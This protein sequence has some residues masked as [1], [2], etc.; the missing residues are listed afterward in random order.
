MRTFHR[1]A[2]IIIG[3]GALL[4]SLLPPASLSLQA[5]TTEPPSLAELKSRLE[6]ADRQTAMRA[7]QVALSEAGDG[8]TFT[9]QRPARALKGKITP[10][11]AFRDGKGRLCRRV[12]YWLALG[13]YE[14]Q[15]EGIGCRE[16]DGSW[17]LSG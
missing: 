9:W 3:A 2:P 6:P 11:S 7:L 17:S 15:I 12:V 16:T 14:R 1:D 10:V 13:R 5:Q 8:T 4:F